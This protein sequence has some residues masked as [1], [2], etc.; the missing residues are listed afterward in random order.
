MARIEIS[1]VSNPYGTGELQLQGKVAMSGTLTAVT[2][3]LNT[4]SPLKLSTGGVQVAS[5]LQITTNSNPYIDAEDGAG[6]NRFQVGRDP[7]SQVVNVDFAS[8]PTGGT[9]MV[10]GIRT[11]TDGVNLS[12]VMSFRKDGWIGVNTP[13]PDSRFQVYSGG[14][15]LRIG[16]AGGGNNYI[17]GSITYVSGLLNA[18]NYLSVGVQ[19]TANRCTIQG[20]GS[21]SATTSLLVQNSSG[22]NALQITDDRT[23]TITGTQTNLSTNKV[24]VGALSLT[25]A[26]TGDTGQGIY[27]T[28]VDGQMILAGSLYGFVIKSWANGTVPL[29]NL[30]N[31]KNLLSIQQYGFHNGNTDGLTGNTLNLAPIY[32]FTSATLSNMVRGIYY[33]PTLTSLVSTTHIAFE[34]TTG[35]VLLNTTSGNTLIGSSVSNTSKLSIKGSGSTSGTTSLLVQNSGGTSAMTIKDDLSTN[36]GG[37]L[38]LVYNS[39]YISASG[40]ANSSTTFIANTSAGWN[41]FAFGNSSLSYFA[42]IRTDRTNVYTP[43]FV[44]LVG[45]SSSASPPTPNASAILQADSTTQ[46][47]LPPR[48]TD[49]QVRAIVS[50]AVGL[51]AYNTDLDCPVFYSTAGWRKVS[52]SVM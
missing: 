19:S 22:S 47:F 15:A 27:S 45:N 3:N 12:Q 44:T 39:S 9:N 2:D 10:G 29:F 13:S 46:G 28:G 16:Y 1:S 31:P 8:N 50:P 21:T 38:N 7:S 40:G 17:D 23:T 6:N 37:I 14:G 30:S 42:E 5:T 26:G 49:A 24:Y 52:H 11:Y 32:N 51:M 41:G 25:S 36:L 34:N 35:D 48:M 33:N 20:S 18:Q 43:L 4:A